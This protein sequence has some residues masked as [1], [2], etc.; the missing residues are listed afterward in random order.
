MGTSYSS[1]MQST[2]F[3]AAL[4][5]AIFDG[6]LRIYFAQVHEAMALKIYFFLTKQCSEHMQKAK[7][8]SKMLDCNCLIMLYPNSET[9]CT[10]CPTA[11]ENQ[12]HFK[13]QLGN[14]T[15]LGLRVLNDI[16]DEATLLDFFKEMLVEW[17]NE[18]RAIQ[19]S[20][21]AEY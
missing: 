20:F 5:S 9:F 1:L 7:T 18:N 4:N 14:D 6:P 17:E 10:A 2:Y 21:L 16:L 11:P 3:N 12:I 8:L 13:N 15:I 19:Q